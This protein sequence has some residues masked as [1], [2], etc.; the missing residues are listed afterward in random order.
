[1]PSLRVTTS[2]GQVFNY[3]IVKEKTT[4]GRSKDND[5]VI[6]DNTVSRHHAEIR[7]S[8][9]GYMIVDLG[10]YNGTKINNKLI[11]VSPLMDNDLVQIGL[12][13]I[14]FLDH[15][16]AEAPDETLLFAPETD[17]A[18]S[19]YPVIATS[20]FKSYGDSSEL[21]F[22][23]EGAKPARERAAESG[24]MHRPR[25]Q[26]LAV[27]ER[28]NKVLF[29]L[30]EI[31]RQLN[32]IHDLNELLEKIMQLIFMVIDADAGFLM[33]LG[34]DGEDNFIPVVVKHRDHASDP[35]QFTRPSK[36]LMRK[37]IRDKVALLTSNAMEDAR[38]DGSKS[39]VIQ[40]IRS[41]MCVPLWRKDKIIG[42]I[43]LDSTRPEAHFTNEDL[44]LLKA[45]AGQMALIIEQASLNEQIRQ[46]ELMRSRLE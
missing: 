33:L 6:A 21:I 22:N 28:S 44:E 46:E 5:V 15:P 9:E 24:Q 11:Q 37:V 7:R 4:L 29:V 32:E 41:A 25:D 19:Q 38:F 10:S 12:A 31:S 27:L 39:V 16:H 40:R 43:Q 26:Y 23:I 14:I 36:T 34:S 18:H 1:M 13:K 35:T 8:N 2:D 45:I 42:V 3:P 20:P 30:Y 17:D